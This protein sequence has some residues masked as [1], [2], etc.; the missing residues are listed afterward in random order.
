LITIRVPGD[1]SICHRALILTPLAEGTS[2]IRGLAGGADVEA[3]AAAMRALGA[4]SLPP[5]QAGAPFEVGGPLELRSPESIIDCGNSGTTARLLIGLVAGSPAGATLDGDDSLRRRPMARVV[6]PL[7]QAGAVVRELRETGHLPVEIAG[8]ALHPIEHESEVASAQVKSALLLAGLA[9]R[10]PVTVIE[11]GASRDHTE[12]MLRAMGANVQTEP[13]QRGMRVRLDVPSGPLKPIDMVVPGDFSSAAFWLGL[14]V[15]GGC[16]DEVRV[17][18]VGLNRGRTGFLRALEAMGASFDVVETG[19]EAGE[20]VGDVVARPSALRG[21][22]VAPEW[23]P[24]LIDE[25]PILACLASRAV[26][27][28]AIRGARE[29]RVKESDRIAALH[30]NLVALGVSS[31]ELPDGLEIEGDVRPLSGVVAARGDHRIAMA[32]GVLGA[33]PGNS[34]E[35]DDKACAQ[36]SYRGFWDELRRIATPR[37]EP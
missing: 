7:R 4:S 1:K 22:E 10:V 23:I 30:A 18:G 3:T 9:S 36:V 21:I 26:G 35:V 13:W 8:R 33:V 12:R 19:D 17:E 2:R 28:T 20:P 29:L 6:Q 14:A 31:R 25:I 15:L 5:L 37:A 11:P 24:S 27:R 32:F 16:G 34:I